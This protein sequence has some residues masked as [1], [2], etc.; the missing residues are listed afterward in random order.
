MLHSCPK[1]EA[2]PNSYVQGVN[3]RGAIYHCVLNI[4]VTYAD[5]LRVWSLRFKGLILKV[6]R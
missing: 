4:N 2:S 5:I 1:I 6:Y 3:R